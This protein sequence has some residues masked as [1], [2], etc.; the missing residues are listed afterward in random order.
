MIS[1]RRPVN[2]TET[3]QRLTAIQQRI[4]QSWAPAPEER[5]RVLEARARVLAR[6]PEVPKVGAEQL[7][8]VEFLLAYERYGI[9][10]AYVR[11]VYPLVELT[12]LPGTPP[13]VLGIA[14]VRGQIVSVMDIKRFF[15]LP[16][17]GLT[18][19]NQLLIVRKG[20]MELGILADE[21]LG[22]RSI[23]LEEMQPRLPTMTGV[24][25]QYLRGITGD[26]LAI[27]D[28]ESILG[29]RR[30]IVEKQTESGG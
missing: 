9:A 24:R 15:D 1:S 29:D 19:L 22:V 6:E 8:I 13:F 14:N 5:A 30:I 18:N 11:E 21:V 26:R 28:I 20:D 23:G 12:P 27:L 10:T 16:E 17:K 7:D 25:A 2:W 3:R 4:E